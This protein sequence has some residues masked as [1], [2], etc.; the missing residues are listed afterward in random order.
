MLKDGV[1]EGFSTYVSFILIV[2]NLLRVFWWVLDRFSLVILSAAVLMILC[3]L[4]L[5]YAWVHILNLPE[6]QKNLREKRMQS[7][8]QG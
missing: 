4:I 1:C 5:L 7:K 8:I 6:D 2:S 3:Q